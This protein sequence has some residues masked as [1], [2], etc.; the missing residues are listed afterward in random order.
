MT[1][2]MKS[3]PCHEKRCLNHLQCYGVCLFAVR[4]L[5]WILYHKR[6]PVNADIM[7]DPFWRR[8]I[9]LFSAVFLDIARY[10]LHVLLRSLDLSF[11]QCS[12][13]S[14]LYHNAISMWNAIPFI[15]NKLLSTMAWWRRT[16]YFL[17]RLWTCFRFK[18][19]EMRWY[20]TFCYN[21]KHRNQ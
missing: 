6:K 17:E 16:Q 2:N 18:K 10:F 21:A 3:V 4:Y 15:Q 8:L 1:L 9:S 5:F 19:F 11:N 12:S 20:Y 14:W 13:F 7:K